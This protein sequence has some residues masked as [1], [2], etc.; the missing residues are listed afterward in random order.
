MTLPRH[1]KTLERKGTMGFLQQVLLSQLNGLHVQAATLGDVHRAAGAAARQPAAAPAAGDDAVAGAGIAVDAAA[2]APAV[3]P[4]GKA[5]AGVR[6]GA[7]ASDAASLQVAC[8][9]NADA[10]FASLVEMAKEALA[11]YKK[12]HPEDA[13]SDP[14][15]SYVLGSRNRQSIRC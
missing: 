4:A 5:A 9:P 8:D 15:Y 2:A 7:V 14:L 6:A 13:T 10:M 12:Q 11:E 1:I 3:A